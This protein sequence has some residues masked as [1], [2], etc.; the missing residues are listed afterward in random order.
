MKNRVLL[1][2]DVFYDDLCGFLDLNR[3]LFSIICRFRFLSNY[4]SLFNC[5]RFFHSG[6]FFSSSLFRSGLFSSSLFCGGLFCGSLFSSCLR[7]CGSPS[8]GFPLQY[9]SGLFDCN[10]VEHHTAP[11]RPNGRP[12]A[13]V[14]LVALCIALVVRRKKLG[15]LLLQIFGK[16][17]Q[18]QTFQD[19]RWLWSEWG[20]SSNR[21]NT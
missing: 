16:N 6:S 12:K 5:G 10:L 20:R 2:S 4:L 21:S 9:G 1:V 3:L 19:G 13:R 11:V 17:L 18:R 7:F 8:V 15:Q 14:Q